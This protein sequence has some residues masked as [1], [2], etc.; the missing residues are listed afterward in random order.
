[1]SST[2]YVPPTS[3]NGMLPQ[4]VP[5]IP[6]F[7]NVEGF[8][9]ALVASIMAMG[10]VLF[11]LAILLLIFVSW[12]IKLFIKW[13]CPTSDITTWKV[14]GIIVLIFIAAAIVKFM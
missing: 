3:L 4:T 9:G 7:R 5:S 8:L 1:M 12:L 6:G 10:I 14:A 2:A 11:I 13:I